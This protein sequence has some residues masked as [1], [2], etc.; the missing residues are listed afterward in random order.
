MGRINKY[1]YGYKI[2]GNYGLGWEDECFEYTYKEARKQLRAYKE[3]SPY[4]SRMVSA[5]EPNPEHPA[6]QG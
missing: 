5:R 2:Q 4:P 1:I 3:N 6:N